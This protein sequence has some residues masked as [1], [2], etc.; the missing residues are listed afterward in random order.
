MRDKIATVLADDEKRV[1]FLEF[2]EFL[3]T[4]NE[5]EL[6]EMSRFV[7]EASGKEVI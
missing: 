3:T 2:L 1:F 4:A 5:T 7:R 6:E